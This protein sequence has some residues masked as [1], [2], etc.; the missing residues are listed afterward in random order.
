M[1][2]TWLSINNMINVV[3]FSNQYSHISNKDY[4]HYLLVKMSKFQHIM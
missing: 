4:A 1:A 2:L 3:I